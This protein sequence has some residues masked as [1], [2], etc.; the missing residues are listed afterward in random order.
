MYQS[1]RSSPSRYLRPH[2]VFFGHIGIVPARNDHDATD[3][4]VLVATFV[5]CS[6]LRVLPDWLTSIAG[7]IF[8]QFFWGKTLKIETFFWKG[9]VYVVT[10]TRLRGTVMALDWC[11]LASFWGNWMEFMNHFKCFVARVVWY[12]KWFAAVPFPATNVGESLTNI[13]W[14]RG[15]W[16]WVKPSSFNVSVAR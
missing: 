13:P 9:R 15:K 1:P 5:A 4:D 3:L 14:N 6:N 16:W 2:S 8:V 11:I 10:K 12:Q 7:V